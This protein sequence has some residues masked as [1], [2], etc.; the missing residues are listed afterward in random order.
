M[1]AAGDEQQGDDGEENGQETSRDAIEEDQ[2]AVMENVQVVG[3]K[4][5]VRIGFRERRFDDRRRDLERV[6]ALL[7]A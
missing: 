5:R 6:Q 4:F 1:P 2:L 3:T 7:D